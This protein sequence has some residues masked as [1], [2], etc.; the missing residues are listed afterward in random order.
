MSQL[1]KFYLEKFVNKMLSLK[2]KFHKLVIRLPPSKWKNL[3]RANLLDTTSLFK[4]SYVKLQENNER[5]QCGEKT[6]KFQFKSP[7]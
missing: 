4:I 7:H 6:T 3:G 2:V 5:T 1:V